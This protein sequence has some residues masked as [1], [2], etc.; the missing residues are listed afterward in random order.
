MTGKK[1][2]KSRLLYTVLF[3]F[4]AM[5][6]FAEPLPDNLNTINCHPFFSD[7]SLLHPEII[8]DIAAIRKDV[9]KNHGY[10]HVLIRYPG[11]KKDLLNYLESFFRVLECPETADYEFNKTCRQ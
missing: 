5:N 11:H 4:S 1:S 7:Q 3:L 8:M 6:G 10:H 9:G 2:I